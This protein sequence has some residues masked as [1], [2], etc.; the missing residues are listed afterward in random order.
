MVEILEVY[1]FNLALD[2]FKG[3]S[4]DALSIH[5]FSLMR[6]VSNLTGAGKDLIIGYYKHGKR[7]DVLQNELQLKDAKS[8]L[9]MTL[10]RLRENGDKYRAIAYRNIKDTEAYQEL[11]C[12]FKSLERRVG[13]V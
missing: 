4:N 11:W 6:T 8:L 13:G 1:P 10:G 12:A 2:I 5:A 7:L 9:G 3:N